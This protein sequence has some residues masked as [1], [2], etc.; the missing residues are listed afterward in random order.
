MEPVPQKNLLLPSFNVGY[1]MSRSPKEQPHRTS[2]P[3]PQDN[4]LLL[5]KAGDQTPSERPLYISAATTSPIPASHTASINPAREHSA[6]GGE[7]WTTSSPQYPPTSMGS[8]SHSPPPP[9]P[10]P[11]PPSSSSAQKHVERQP[12]QS[13][14]TSF[15]ASPPPPPGASPSASV[16]S[17]AEATFPG[18]LPSSRGS[19]AV[20]SNYEQVRSPSGHSSLASTEQ[21]SLSSRHGS[22]SSEPGQQA[23]AT[24]SVAGAAVDSS[25]QPSGRVRRRPKTQVASACWKC[26]KDHLSCDPGRPCKRCINSGQQVSSFIGTLHALPLPQSSTYMRLTHT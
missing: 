24:L 4:A 21:Q 23:S 7:R 17:T 8:S 16:S 20:P 19:P 15:I 13:T 9:P 11:P 25:G 10:P 18:A 1:K 14:S 2:P 26:K 12:P 22:R 5:S 6:S 3:P